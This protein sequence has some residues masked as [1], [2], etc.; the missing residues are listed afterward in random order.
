MLYP[1][2]IE[3]YDELGLKINDLLKELGMSRRQLSKEVGISCPY[4]TDIL[5][6]NR[7]TSPKIPII[8]KFLK[9][10]KEKLKNKQMS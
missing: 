3:K 1:P 2:K 10:E 7:P 5:Q 6:G 9:D 8:F 4:V